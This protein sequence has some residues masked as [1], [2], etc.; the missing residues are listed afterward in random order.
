MAESD[1]GNKIGDKDDNVKRRNTSLSLS[2]VFDPGNREDLLAH[3]PAPPFMMIS[4]YSSSSLSAVVPPSKSN[5]R[6]L[7][8]N[9]QQLVRTI[10]P[11]LISTNSQRTRT[12]RSVYHPGWT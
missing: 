9:Y 12:D 2:V 11:N 7:R 6:T 8:N 5:R 4:P 10:N 1:G 3:P